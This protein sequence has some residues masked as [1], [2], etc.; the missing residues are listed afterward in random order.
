MLKNLMKNGITV[1]AAV[2][3]MALIG[4]GEKSGTNGSAPATPAND[5]TADAGHADAGSHDPA[6]AGHGGDT[7]SGGAGNASASLD[8]SSAEAALNTYMNRL[9]SGDFLGAAE[10][11]LADAP[12]TAE[13]ITLGTNFANMAN[14][15]ENASIGATAKAIFTDE[16]KTMESV[17]VLEEEGVVVYEVSLINKSPVNIRVENRDGVWRVIPPINGTP[18]G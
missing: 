3:A 1:F 8:D 17:K 7:H 16:F 15:P 2:G 10:V 14:D 12:G 11:C 9:K 6:D 18:T 5:A 13:L 4:C